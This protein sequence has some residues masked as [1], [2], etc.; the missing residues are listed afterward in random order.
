MFE[1]Y[2]NLHETYTLSFQF[3]VNPANGVLDHFLNVEN[4]S[5]GF[6]LISW[7][8]HTTRQVCI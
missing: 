1:E 8:C 4:D 5:F 3:F 2:S 7:S 6:S